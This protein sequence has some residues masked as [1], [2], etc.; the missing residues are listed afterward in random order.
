MLRAVALTCLLLLPLALAGPQ[1]ITILDLRIVPD[2]HTSRITSPNS[3]ADVAYQPDADGKYVV[4]VVLYEKTGGAWHQV[5]AQ[6]TLRVFSEAPFDEQSRVL[7]VFT[8]SATQP[9]RLTFPA[10]SVAD[11]HVFDLFVTFHCPT[12]PAGQAWPTSHHS[13]LRNA[14]IGLG[15]MDLADELDFNHFLFPVGV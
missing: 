7:Q 11:T 13:I 2:G 12:C 1:P 8:S 15:Q 9:T 14:V 4:D 6:A 10:S 5:A 3:V